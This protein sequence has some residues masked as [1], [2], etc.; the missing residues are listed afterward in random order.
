MTKER[1]VEADT[2]VIDVD[3]MANV[4]FVGVNRVWLFH[5][6]VHGAVMKLR[7]RHAWLVRAAAGRTGYCLESWPH[8]FKRRRRPAG[9]GPQAL[10]SG[11]A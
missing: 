3:A 11:D 7:R 9:G 1:N 8:H 2:A 10:D 4:A 6:D 5:V